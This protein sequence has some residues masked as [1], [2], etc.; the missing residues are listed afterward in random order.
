M[1][2]M[3]LTDDQDMTEKGASIMRSTCRMSFGSWFKHAF[4]QAA[5]WRS[6]PARHGDDSGP[7]DDKVHAARGTADG[8][9]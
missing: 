9:I 3:F 8:Q 1:S 2:Q 6:C 5:T 7:C 4:I